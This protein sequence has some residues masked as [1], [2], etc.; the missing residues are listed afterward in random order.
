MVMARDKLHAVSL[1]AV[2]RGAAPPFLGLRTLLRHL[3]FSLRVAVE[4]EREP[5]YTMSDTKSTH[6][7]LEPLT[8]S[9]YTATEIERGL[10]SLAFNAGNSRNAEKQLKSEGIE[11]PA[12]TLRDWARN[13]F[14]RRYLDICDRH[15]REIED[16]YVARQRE[17]ALQA[18]DAAAMAVA[19]TIEDLK[20]GKLKD[21]AG[22][23]RNLEVV[24]G[25]AADKVLVFT[26]RPNNISEQRN[27]EEL[28]AKLTR[29]AGSIPG[30]AT[31]MESPAEAGLPSA[32]VM[33]LGRT[34]G[35]P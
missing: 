18:S 19:Q 9:K 32:E 35:Q 13:R 33:G 26:G 24:S 31:E 23:A 15:G 28:L 30:T 16:T 14:A 8:S 34:F 29:L 22:A 25:T 20:A 7:D 6:T 17:L 27:P 2:P 1:E 21:P 3:G 11:I 10:I 12:V 4:Q 5:R